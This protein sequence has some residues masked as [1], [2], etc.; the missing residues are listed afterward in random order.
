MAEDASKHSLHGRV[1]SAFTGHVARVVPGPP[2]PP[3]ARP[4]YALQTL[5]LCVV[6]FSLAVSPISLG[7]GPLAS[8][9][10]FL[11]WIALTAPMARRYGL[12]R[13]ALFMEAVS[14]T[15]LSAVT[16]LC[17]STL[18]G[19]VSGPFVDDL[20]VRAD[21]FMGYDWWAVFRLSRLYPSVVRSLDLAY[22]CLVPQT[23]LMPLALVLCRRERIM[24]EFLTA[25]TLAGIATSAIFPFAPAKGAALYFAVAP[26]A[27][28]KRWFWMFG[29][30]IEAL[31]RGEA[32]DISRAVMGIVSVPSFHT[33]A[34]VMFTWASRAIPY[35]GTSLVALNLLMIL[36]TPISGIHYLVDVVAGLLVGILSI[37]GAKALTRGRSLA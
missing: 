18:G 36:S 5:F 3:I 4:A 6:A 7:S 22:A 28:T 24:W 35:V 25:W 32:L 2:V 27:F 8:S 11:C 33:A 20:L 15:S 17:A 12:V 23:I 37:V 14:F 10:Y 30:Q 16:T 34:G 1:I 29:P 9:L 19:A 21:L 13:S 26:D 31:R